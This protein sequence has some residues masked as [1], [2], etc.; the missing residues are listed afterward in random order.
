MQ[1]LDREVLLSYPF[2]ILFAGFKSTTTDLQQNGWNLSVR[3]SLQ[4]RR[5]IS[6]AFQYE[7]GGLYGITNAVD[8]DF[9]HRG[10]ALEDRLKSLF[11]TVAYIGNSPRFH[12]IAV[13]GPT[14]LEDFVPI[15]A[16][17]AFGKYQSFEDFSIF[18]RLD[19]TKDVLID[20]N[21]VPELMSLILKAQRPEQEMIRAREQS[22]ENM[23]KWRESQPGQERPDMDFQPNTRVA[24]QIITLAG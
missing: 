23:R 14:F 3:E 21:D 12:V 11:F 9:E 8:F 1:K 20:P 16:S 19:K 15:D 5:S 17:P 4:W 6:L 10:Y 7:K 24:A 13:E 18:R 22:R 2:P